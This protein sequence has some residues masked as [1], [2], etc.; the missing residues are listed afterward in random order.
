MSIANHNVVKAHSFARQ[1]EEAIENRQWEAAVH[2]Y[3][4]AADLFLLATNDTSDLESIKALQLLSKAQANKSKALLR[5]LQHFNARTTEQTNFSVGTPDRIGISSEPME[6]ISLSAS[7]NYFVGQVPSY[8]TYSKSQQ[9]I[10]LDEKRS[11]TSIDLWGWMERMLETYLPESFKS[12]V[13]TSNDAVQNSTLMTSFYFVPDNNKD[14]NEIGG[15]LQDGGDEVPIPLSNSGRDSEV[16]E[17]DLKVKE[18]QEKIVQLTDENTKLKQKLQNL[19]I[20]RM[21]VSKENDI[22]K[23]SI[24]QFRQEFRKRAHQLRDISNSVG[25]LPTFEQNYQP[26]HE[27]EQMK[28][29]INQLQSQ[30]VAMTQSQNNNLN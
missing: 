20:E 6:E 8:N 3:Q 7:E 10:R 13:T 28:L 27:Q 22:M 29:Q 2:L 5:H 21:E 12:P 23:K 19:Y 30:L 16:K 11:I 17:L 15:R 24:L 14:G 25:Y 4:Q 1:A 26:Q 18:L 9:N